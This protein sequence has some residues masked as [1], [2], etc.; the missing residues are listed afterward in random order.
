LHWGFPDPSSFRGTPAEVLQ[1]TREVRDLIRQKI[2]TCR[3]CSFFRPGK[4]RFRVSRF[5]LLCAFLR[6]IASAFASPSL[7]NA[8]ARPDGAPGGKPCRNSRWAMMTCSKNH[9]NSCY[10]VDGQRFN[11]RF[12]C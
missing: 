1:K 6:L 9:Q 3:S 10:H 12:A 8:S 11:M 4:A 2:K 5:F 7:R